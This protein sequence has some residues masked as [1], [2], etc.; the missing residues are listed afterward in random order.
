MVVVWTQVDLSF[1]SVHLASCM[2]CPAPSFYS[3]E[4]PVLA[5]HIG[6][7]T[8]YQTSCLQRLPSS[9]TL[10]LPHHFT[11]Q[12]GPWPMLLKT[13]GY[14]WAWWK[15]L[16][17]AGFLLKIHNKPTEKEME[18]EQGRSLCPLNHPSMQQNV[19]DL[20]LHVGAE[21]SPIHLSFKQHSDA[22]R[23]NMTTSWGMCYVA[24]DN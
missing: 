4:T 17:T 18:P 13:Q 23:L 11:K 14:F 2:W 16:W 12:R 6:T 22:I 1:S 7:P 15:G 10:C 8:R 19:P 9:L 20:A 21:I 24:L 5:G 3:R